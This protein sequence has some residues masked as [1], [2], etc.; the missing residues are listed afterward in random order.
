[1]GGERKSR[2]GRLRPGKIITQVI[3]FLLLG[4]IVNV[5][6]AWWCAW[7][8]TADPG[9]LWREYANGWPRRV[10]ESW[11]APE[12]EYW[13]SDFGAALVQIVGYSEDHYCTLALYQC[14]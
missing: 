11:P 13:D 4:A 9:P 2:R 1:M 3:V 12:V 14:G 6:V 7:W 8:W 10:P 5:A